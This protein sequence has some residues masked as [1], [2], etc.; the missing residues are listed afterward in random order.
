ML[1]DDSA[2]AISSYRYSAYGEMLDFTGVVTDGYYYTGEYMD[3]AVEFDT[4]SERDIWI[5]QQ[6]HLHPWTAT[7]ET[8]MSLL[9]YTD[10][11]MQTL[12]L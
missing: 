11:S 12:T 7:Q 4:T 10:I 1:L 9:L 6:Q 2:S 5:R 8:S 3:P